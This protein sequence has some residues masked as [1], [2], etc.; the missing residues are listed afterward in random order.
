MV[1]AAFPLAGESM[2]K[3]E[4][5][6]YLM[7]PP[8]FAPAEL[9]PKL[10]EAL[11]TGEVASV[12]LWLADDREG[13]WQATVTALLPVCHAQGVPLILGGDDGRAARLGADGIHLEASAAE[14]RA[15]QKAH[16]PRLMVG[17]GGLA[18]RHEAMLAAESGVDYVFFGSAD[19]ARERPIAA[20]TVLDLAEWCSELF[21]IPCVAHA[22][23]VEEAVALGVA[24]ADFIAAGALVWNDPAGPAAAVKALADAMQTTVVAP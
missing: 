2:S 24:G 23:S 9:A 10:A 15:A 3:A 21:Q 17:A 6:L 8:A 7:L 4:P 22:D 18:S 5:R 14:V 16:A 19:P 12:L 1:R 11:A 13:V 20:T